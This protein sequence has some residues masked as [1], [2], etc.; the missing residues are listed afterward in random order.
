MNEILRC[1]V[2]VD[3]SNFVTLDNLNIIYYTVLT[4]I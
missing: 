1:S 2:A 3:F 4:T